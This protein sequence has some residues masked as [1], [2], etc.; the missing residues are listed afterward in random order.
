MK[1]GGQGHVETLFHSDERMMRKF[2]LSRSSRTFLTS[3][4]HNTSQELFSSSFL[5][6]VDI[7]DTQINA[8]KLCI[9]ATRDN[10]KYYYLN[11]DQCLQRVP[12]ILSKI[13][14]FAKRIVN[15]QRH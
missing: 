15:I 3:K 9:N 2:N 12:S 5:G 14:R 4:N 1:R 6:S 7:P 11:P 10:P 13:E 8:P